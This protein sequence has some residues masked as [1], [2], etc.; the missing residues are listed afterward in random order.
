MSIFERM[1]KGKMDQ[2]TN[3]DEDDNKPLFLDNNL[4]QL[5]E[6]IGVSSDVIIRQIRFGKNRSLRAAIVYID[7]LADKKS[8]Q[9]NIL[10]PLMLEIKGTEL[11]E[12]ISLENN[13]LQ[14][15]KESILTAGDIQDI[16]NLNELFE[17][18][19]SGYAIL[20][21][22]QSAVGLAFGLNESK[23]RAVSEPTTQT[24]VRGPKEVFSESIATN[25]V[26]IR[27]K[28]KDSRLQV[29]N[30]SAGKVTNISLAIIYI[31]GLVE[32]NLIQ[33]IRN[34]IKKID[35]SGVL[36][37]GMIEESIQ[38]KKFTPFPTMYNSERPDVIAA[39]LLEGRV[40]ILVDGTPFVLLVPAIF[41]QFMQSPE[42]YYQ[43]FDIGSIIRF[44]RYIGL[45]LA[46]F[47][48]AI[49]V[50]I[51]TFH[52]EL[53]PYPLLLNL[54]RQHEG[55]P[56]PTLGEALLMLLMFEILREAG[57]RM[58]RVVGQ[59]V[60]IVGAVVIGQAAVEAG[61]VT[62]AVVIVIS[63]TAISSFIIPS[64]NMEIAIRILRVIFMLLS[65]IFG[66]IGVMIGVIALVLHLCSLRSFGVPYM[67]PFSPFIKAGQKDAFIRLPLTPTNKEFKE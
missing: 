7:G 66:L 13:P 37:G 3:Q 34:R 52:S 58:P 36:E 10:D 32:E 28:I 4:E 20:L 63:G 39:G 21:I 12:L 62:A 1:N 14:L 57:I 23:E 50:A 67:T 44:M 49:Y 30:Q 53:I 27:K 54:A 2:P 15:L 64:S 18:L 35:L 61:I 46:L 6:R 31:R 22:D 56:L 11:E 29:E 19:L 38:D 51:T 5:K 43:R 42:D 55:V 65:G 47:G 33:E 9:Q 45:L 26:L 40:A 24:V 17:H 41:S 8:I 60:S 25:I 48:P 59:A 16:G